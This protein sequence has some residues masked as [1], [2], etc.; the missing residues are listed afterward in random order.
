LRQTLDLIE[1][2]AVAQAVDMV[3]FTGDIVDGRGKR[4]RVDFETGFAPLVALL[5][6]LCPV[7]M[8]ATASK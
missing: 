3:V 2:V 8:K 7:I 4:S 1:R 5:Q 6:R